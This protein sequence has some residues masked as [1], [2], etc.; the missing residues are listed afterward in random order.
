MKHV[1][2][3]CEFRTGLGELENSA[4]ELYHSHQQNENNPDLK[5]KR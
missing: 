1:R 3:F 5:N 4:E 2:I